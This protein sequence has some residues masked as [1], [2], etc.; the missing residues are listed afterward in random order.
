[1]ATI[2]VAPRA[3]DQDRERKQIVNDF[4][5]QV[6]TVNG[7]GSQTA[8]TVLLRTIFQMGVLPLN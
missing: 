7:S 3:S 1:M 8:N 5:I 2:D 6:A 4:S